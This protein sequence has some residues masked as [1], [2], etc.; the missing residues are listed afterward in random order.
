MAPIAEMKKRTLKKVSEMYFINLKFNPTTKMVDSIWTPT[1]LRTLTLN[2]CLKSA[3]LY[4]K[5]L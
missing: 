5:L 3:D 4:S 2:F 1:V